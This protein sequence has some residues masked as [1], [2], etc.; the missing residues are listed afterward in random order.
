VTAQE[1]LE[2]RFVPAD[3]EG[4]QQLGIRQT[5][6]GGQEGCSAEMPEDVVHVISSLIL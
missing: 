4:L 1:Y 2:G 6:S 5:L 3:Q